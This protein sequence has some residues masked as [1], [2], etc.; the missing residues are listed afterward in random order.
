MFDVCLWGK[1]KPDW[2]YSEESVT[3]ESAFKIE[4]VYFFLPTSRAE[5][6]VFVYAAFIFHFHILFESCWGSLIWSWLMLWWRGSLRITIA[7]T[8]FSVPYLILPLSVEK[9]QSWQEEKQLAFSCWPV[10]LFPISCSQSPA[11]SSSKCSFLC[12]HK[13]HHCGISFRCFFLSLSISAIAEPTSSDWGSRISPYFYIS[14]ACPTY[15][16]FLQ[17]SAELLIFN[18]VQTSSP[19]LPS[20]HSL[21]PAV[22]WFCL[23]KRFPPSSESFKF[24]HNF[25]KGNPI[26]ATK[27]VEWKNKEGHLH[28]A[29]G[30]WCV[31]WEMRPR[32]PSCFTDLD[33]D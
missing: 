5:H 2:E 9:K 13:K 4:N 25:C 20:P 29:G 6:P 31:V 24:T 1:W 18:L 7:N 21:S 14:V 16:G 12:R 22:L 11:T 17:L 19:Y 3:S 10:R 15:L 23:D 28:G 26:L 8:I 30:K 33:I 32:I 27:P